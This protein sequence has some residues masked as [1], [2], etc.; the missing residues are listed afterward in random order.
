MEFASIDE[1]S[2]TN[3]TGTLTGKDCVLDAAS[4]DG[5]LL[6]WQAGFSSSCATGKG[7]KVETDNPTSMP[8]A[9]SLNPGTFGFACPKCGGNLVTPDADG[10]PVLHGIARRGMSDGALSCPHCQTVCVPR[11]SDFS[12]MH[13]C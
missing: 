7:T 6:H 4:G 8:T 10:H 11:R 13:D 1:S 2:G 3:D 12:R 5:G 9:A